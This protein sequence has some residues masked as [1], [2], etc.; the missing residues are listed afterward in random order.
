M[1][2]PSD[3]TCACPSVNACVHSVESV[4]PPSLGPKIKSFFDA[5]ALHRELQKKRHARA[6]EYRA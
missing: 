1:D 4:T 6:R 3:R 5:N 2:V